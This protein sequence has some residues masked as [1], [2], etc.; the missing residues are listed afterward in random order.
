MPRCIDGIDLIL[1]VDSQ[2]SNRFRNLN[3]QKAHLIESIAFDLQIIF[4]KMKS[5][6]LK[7]QQSRV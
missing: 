2:N 7:G 4:R 1:T 5:K 6:N 3:F